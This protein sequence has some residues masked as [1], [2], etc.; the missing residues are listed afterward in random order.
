VP[1]PKPG[2]NMRT[3]LTQFFLGFERGNSHSSREESLGGSRHK[4]IEREERMVRASSGS[5]QFKSSEFKLQ[6]SLHIKILQ[7]LI[8]NIL[9]HILLNNNIIIK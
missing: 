3:S 6:T 9:H 8:Y 4:K 7:L 5:L 2:L 1:K